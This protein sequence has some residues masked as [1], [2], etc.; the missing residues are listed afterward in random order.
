[1]S[2]LR[3]KLVRLDVPGGR[4]V[5]RPLRIGVWCDYGVTLT[6]TEGIGVFV[7]N[8]IGGLLEL[9]EPLEVVVL[10]TPGDRHLVAPLQKRFSNRLHVVPPI[11]P[12]SSELPLIGSLIEAGVRFI[13]RMRRRIYGLSRRIRFRSTAEPGPFWRSLDSA[14]VRIEKIV[15]A[16]VAI[17]SRVPGIRHIRANWESIFNPLVVCQNA[18]CDVWLIPSDRFRFLLTFPSVLVIHDLVHVHYPDA[19]PE[20]VCWE[21]KRVVPARSAEATLCACMSGYIRDVDLRGILGL[22]VEKIR[23]IPP[24]PPADFPEI[25]HEEAARLKP[26]QMKRPYLFYPAAFRSYKNHAAL[27]DALHVL[28][29]GGDHSLDLVFTGIHNLPKTLAQR[30]KDLNLTDRVHVLGCVDRRT[31]AALYQNAFS[32]IVPSLYEQGSFPIYEALHWGCPVAC[33]NIPSLVEQCRQLG[34]AMIYF[35]PHDPKAIAEAILQ[36][37][38][39]PEGILARQQAAKSI[40]WQR[41]WRDA[42]RDWLFVL[43]EAIYLYQDQPLRR[44]A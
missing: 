22:P 4:S 31:L 5:V 13:A 8:L 19:V 34:D 27:I 3:R 32:T 30:I 2:G 9:P 12:R 17:S 29:S 43:R 14:I 24:A 42:A 18:D 25:T 35:D 33:S 20:D 1:M 39:D 21:L 44:S 10:A 28:H 40:L 36:L 37:R 11:L 38:N 7:W 15:C 41:S 23:L 26:V 16:C 6:P